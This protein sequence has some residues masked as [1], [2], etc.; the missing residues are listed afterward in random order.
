MELVTPGLGLIVWTSIA[1]LTVLFLLKKFAWKTILDSIHER[2]QKIDSALKS[3]E[4]AEKRM[5][6][7]QSKN[8]NL[9]AEAVKEREKIMKT[10][11][12]VSEKMINEAR[13][14]A[15]EEAS[16]ILEQAKENIHNEKMKAMVEIKNEIG[17]L[18]LEIAEKIMKVKMSDEEMQKETFKKLLN[19]VNIN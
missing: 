6:E 17:Q 15:S 3:A 7:I 11:R 9:L 19:E 12:E 2:E 10:A 1:F 5:S 18:S 14:K 16:K 4:E 13:E 8:E